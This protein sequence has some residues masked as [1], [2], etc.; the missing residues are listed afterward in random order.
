MVIEHQ[1]LKA[2]KVLS[3]CTDVSD[4][5]VPQMIKGIKENI[6]VLRFNICGD[7]IVAKQN[8]GIEFL[9]PID[10]EFSSNEHYS[11]KERVMLVN[12][13]RLRH[14]GS[15]GTIR[16]SLTELNEYIAERQLTPITAPYIVERDNSDNAYDIYIGISENVV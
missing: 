15:F 5:L 14:Y 1:T 7:I 4:D 8:G 10:R 11:F 13:A 3:H 6:S 12:A 2:E 9:V 16:K